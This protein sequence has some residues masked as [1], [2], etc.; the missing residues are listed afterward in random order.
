[1]DISPVSET[2]AFVSYTGNIYLLPLHDCAFIKVGMVSGEFSEPRRISFRPDGKLFAT[3]GRGD[4]ALEF[5]GIPSSTSNNGND[6]TT[7]V[8]TMENQPCPKIP[9]I[10]EQ[11]VPEYDWW[12]Q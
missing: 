3:H 7:D 10:V 6:T 1:M 5:W 9:M 8:P 2:V 12:G 11:P 4:N